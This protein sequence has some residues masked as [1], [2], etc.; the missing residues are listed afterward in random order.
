MSSIAENIAEKNRI[1]RKMA[2][3]KLIFDRTHCSEKPPTEQKCQQM[4]EE[5]LSLGDTFAY[6]PRAPKGKKTK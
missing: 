3:A 6:V 4:A 1:D 2:I 5:I